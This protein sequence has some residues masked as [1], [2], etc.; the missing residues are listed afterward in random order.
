MSAQGNLFP[1]DAFEFFP[2]RLFLRLCK[3]LRSRH[4]RDDNAACFIGKLCKDMC[5]GIKSLNAPLV[6]EQQKE[7]QCG[8]AD[9]PDKKLCE[10]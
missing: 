2:Q 1:R 4:I 7:M 6:N 8:L 9:L 10:E 5:D 3:R